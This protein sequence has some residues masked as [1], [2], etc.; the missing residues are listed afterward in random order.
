MLYDLTGQCF[1]RL[2]VL[3]KADYKENNATIWKCKCECGNLTYQR[4]NAIKS[5]KVKSCG[6]L[7]R[8]IARKPKKHGMYNTR[9]YKTYNSMKARC[10]KETDARYANYGAKGITICEE[11]LGDDGFINFYKW[12]MANGYEDYLTI[13]RIDSKGNY[14]PSNCRWVGY[15]EQNNNTSRNHLITYNGETHTIAEWAKILG[16]NYN[17][18]NQRL[19]KG[20]P[21]DVALN[22]NYL[23]KG[24]I[25]QC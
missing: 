2:T 22:R 10:T 16:I 8:E 9:I 13:D 19:W 23:K 3:S 4:T 14:E 15:V 21:I 11:W 5:G 18:L 6:C 25:G 17:T 1:N 7:Q 20:L 24:K 12:A